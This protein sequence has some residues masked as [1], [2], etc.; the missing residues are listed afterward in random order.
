M[1]EL[2]DHGLDLSN[3]QT[4]QD[5]HHYWTTVSILIYKKL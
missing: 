1:A 2:L 5:N 3:I 4:E